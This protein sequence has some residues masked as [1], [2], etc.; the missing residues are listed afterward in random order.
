MVKRIVIFASGA[1]SNAENIIQHFK[2]D[3]RVCIAGVCSNKADAGVVKIAGRY[4][5]ECLVFT[6]EELIGSSRVDDFLALADPKLIVL[7]GFL[8]KF[9]ER[10]V[11]RYAGRVVNLHPSLLPKYGGKGMYGQRV[12]E[13]VVAAGESESGITIHYVNNQYDEEAIIEQYSCGLSANDTPITL[14]KKIKD[15][16][17]QYFPATIEK[18]LHNS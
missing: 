18:L 12:H 11:S 17:S 4:G 13:A 6:K 2:S 9:P 15:L 7:A 10:L 16:E 5:V 1:G 14:Q 3:S 8:L